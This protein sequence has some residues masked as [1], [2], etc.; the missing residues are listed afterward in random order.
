[1]SLSHTYSILVKCPL[2]AL[3]TMFMATLSVTAT[4]FEKDGAL[5][6]KIACAWGRMLL[7]IGGVKITVEG[8]EKLKP[9]VCYV[10]TPN[11]LSY[12]DT[13]VLLGGIPVP[14]RFLAKEELF[15]IPFL[16]HHL[17]H[18][19]HIAVPLGEN[20]ASLKVLTQAAHVIR[21][22]NLSVLVFPEGGRAEDGILQPFKEGAVY[23]AIK[24]G[25]PLVPIGL[26]GTYQVL[27]MHSLNI[28]G[29]RVRLRIG[30]PI[31]TEGLHV[32]DRGRLNA[33][34]RERVAEL[35]GHTDPACQTV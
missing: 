28:R 12:M 24:A 5:A 16:G 21:Q 15:Q 17:R 25:A 20:R 2:I 14:F 19:G 13:P 34:L 1:M 27:P 26:V 30:D 11:H 23:M 35:I 3:S 10:L 4:L 22:Q 9:G 7:H 8:A 18:A 31:P 33:M 6:H 29:R 32:R